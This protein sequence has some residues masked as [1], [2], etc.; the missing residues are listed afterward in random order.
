MLGGIANFIGVKQ[1]NV[2]TTPTWDGVDNAESTSIE[3]T[4]D[5]FNDSVEA[6]C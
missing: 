5:L 2:T 1:L 4:V 3:C 6:A